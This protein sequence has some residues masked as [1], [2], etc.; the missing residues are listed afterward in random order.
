MW[1]SRSI[2]PSVIPS[3]ALFYATPIAGSPFDVTVSLREDSSPRHDT[4]EKG[5]DGELAEE[6]EQ[7]AE[8][9]RVRAACRLYATGS[10]W[11]RSPKVGQAAFKCWNL[12]CTYW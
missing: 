5:L 6:K 2:P 3:W 12:V 11:N 9:V 7:T 1:S 8:Q 4:H 10:P